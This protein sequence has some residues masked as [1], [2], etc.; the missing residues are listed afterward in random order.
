MDTGLIIEGIK[1]IKA[2][3][4]Q[5]EAMKKLKPRMDKLKERI[6]IIENLLNYPGFNELLETGDYQQL[7]KAIS[8]LEEI[9]NKDCYKQIV[10]LGK[11]DFVSHVKNFF[12]A[13]EDTLKYEELIREI[14]SAIGN[15][16]LGFDMDNFIK[17]KKFRDTM[18]AIS[19]DVL[20]QLDELT[21]NLKEIESQKNTYSGFGAVVK[22]GKVSGTAYAGSILTNALVEADE[23]GEDA[24]ALSIQKLDDP[25]IPIKEKMELYRE[26]AIE[27]QK[28]VEQIMQK[29]DPLIVSLQKRLENPKITGN[30]WEKCFNKL[31]RR[32]YELK[33]QSAQFKENSS[34]LRDAQDAES[35]SSQAEK[36]KE[37]HSSSP[38]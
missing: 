3:Y 37:R 5:V 16:Q 9:L 30:E 19:K 36:E 27:I 23:V 15:I 4:D 29:R 38:K 21:K 1:A 2:I 25:E 6:D 7:E 24:I 14:D 26:N 8:N 10:K 28:R 13:K 33:E 32:I 31:E 34:S 11:K 18:R 35:S 12:D 20:G 22:V 17:N